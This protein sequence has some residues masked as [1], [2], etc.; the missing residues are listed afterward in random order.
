[1]IIVSFLIVNNIEPAL[2]LT[3]EGIESLIEYLYLEI[4][5]RMWL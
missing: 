4:S 5:L 2:M 1:M 3:D